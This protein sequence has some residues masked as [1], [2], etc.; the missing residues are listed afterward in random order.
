MVCQIFN[1]SGH[2]V[3]LR[4]FQ[5]DRPLF[6]GGQNLAIPYLFFYSSFFLSWKSVLCNVH[7]CR[8]ICSTPFL[9]KVM[10]DKGAA[11]TGVN[12]LPLG[13]NFHFGAFPWHWSVRLLQYIKFFS[14][15]A[16]KGSFIFYFL[17]LR[18]A[19][20]QILLL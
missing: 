1:W 20:G 16:W 10:M 11:M 18:D 2:L 12:I 5:F 6:L 9:T 8:C 13:T 3:F 17:A 15:C 19:D 7:T 4:V 14:S